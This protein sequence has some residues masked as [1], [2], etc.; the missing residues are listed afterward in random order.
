MRKSIILNEKRILKLQKLKDKKKD[1][2]EKYLNKIRQSKANKY[3]EKL[4]RKVTELHWGVAKEISENYETVIIGKFS[5][6]KVNEGEV[7]DMVKR[8]GTIM[9]HYDFRSKLVYKCLSK[10]TKI[11][12]QDEKFT[13]KMCSS[14]GYYNNEVRG[15]KKILCGG[16]KE[17]LDRDKY[18]ARGII[19]KSLK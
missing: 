9:R 14:C 7:A 16:C 8:V 13:T 5:M 19:I 18:S 1:K 15:E 12:I 11:K 3:Y 2:Y 4:K 10:G 17:I 6:K